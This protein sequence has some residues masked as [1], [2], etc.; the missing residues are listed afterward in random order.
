MT[1]FAKIELPDLPYSVNALEP[2]LI[3]EILEIHHGKHHKKYVDEYNKFGEQLEGALSKADYKTA[4]KLAEKIRFNA[5]GHNAHVLYWENLAPVK[6][7]GGSPD[8]N[9]DIV[10]AITK[11][12]GSVQKFID[13][14]NYACEQIQGSGWTWLAACPSTKTLSIK[15]TERHD[16]VEVE[17]LVPLL[18]VDVWEH[19]YY[20][21]YKNLKVEYFKNI[22]NVVNWRTVDDRFHKV[23]WK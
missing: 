3:G 8:P 21:Q 9:S 17:D 15:F 23:Q 13:E 1:S 19:A 6:N 7:G 16:S 12:W 14:F 22:W 4:H 11:E 2:I 5:G 18:T 20:L 10:K